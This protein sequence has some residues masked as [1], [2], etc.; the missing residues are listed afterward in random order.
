VEEIEAEVRRTGLVEPEGLPALRFDPDRDLVFDYGPPLPGHANG[1]V[2]IAC[3]RATPIT[4]R[5]IIRLAAA[6]SSPKRS[7]KGRPGD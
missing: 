7:C 5:S 1:L 3:V 4:G 6:S 2:L